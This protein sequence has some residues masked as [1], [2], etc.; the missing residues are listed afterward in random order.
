MV[1]SLAKRSSNVVAPSIALSGV[2]LFSQLS[3]GSLSGSTGISD[4]ELIIGVIP[5]MSGSHISVLASSQPSYHCSIIPDLYAS[6]WP[7]GVLNEVNQ[8]VA[9]LISG[10]GVLNHG[11]PSTRLYAINGTTRTSSSWTG[12]KWCILWTVITVL[13]LSLPCTITWLSRPWVVMCAASWGRPSL[14]RSCADIMMLVAPQSLTAR[15]RCNSPCW[16]CI[17]ASWTMCDE[18]HLAIPKKYWLNV[19]AFRLPK[20]TLSLSEIGC[21]SFPLMLPSTP[22]YQKRAIQAPIQ[23]SSPAEL[24]TKRGKVVFWLLNI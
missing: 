6:H 4:V 7:L 11:N 24:D 2:G 5:P 19:R 23:P 21:G 3:L 8:P 15:I 1:S 12:A 13:W 22:S 20:T 17:W 9:Q 14:L 16:S 10:L 18:S